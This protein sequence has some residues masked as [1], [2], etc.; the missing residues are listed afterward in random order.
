[1]AAIIP[2]LAAASS[3]GVYATTS[4]MIWSFARDRGLPFSKYLVRVSLCI[5][6]D[7]L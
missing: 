7:L 4:R 1:M 3:I 2:V 6:D 5:I